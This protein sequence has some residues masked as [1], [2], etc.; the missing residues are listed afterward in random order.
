MRRIAIFTDIH[1][2]YEPLE[3]ILKD[4]KSKNIDE[5]YS[6]G[7][8]VGLGPNP[9]ECLELLKKYNVKNVMGN[10]E[11]YV[12][13]G[14]NAFSYF[15]HKNKFRYQKWTD[16][17]LDKNDIDYIKTFK[18]SFILELG[19]KKI[20]LCHFVND[21]RVDYNKYS[22]WSYQDSLKKNDGSAIKQFYY[23]NS[24]EQKELIKEK[25]NNNDNYSIAY[26][27]SYNDPI[28]EGHTIDYFDQIFQ[29][30]V[31]FPSEVSD[32]NVIIT[33]LRGVSIAF[34]DRSSDEAYYV[35]LNEEDG[36]YSIEDCYVKFDRKK[37]IDTIVKSDLTSKGDILNY[38]NG[39]KLYN[40][41]MFGNESGAN[42]NIKYKIGEVNIAEKWNPNGVDASEMG[43]FNFST[44]DKIFRW[45]IRGNTIYD[46][47]IP[48]D[49]S[50]ICVDEDKG[51]YRSNKIILYNPHIVDD[52][53]AMYI[54]K[55]SKLPEKVYYKALAGAAIRGYRNT[56]LKLINDKINKDNVDVVLKEID[57]FVKPENSD[58]CASN[59]VEV[60]NEVISILKKIKNVK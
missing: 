19:G 48:E 55:V 40:R 41:V 46:C 2:L 10:S 47:F 6:L 57:D 39:P 24:D 26:K 60:Y 43:G 13:L 12:L 36:G 25:M 37:M 59:G 15:E 32:S 45:L 29:G 51:V 17:K 8:V 50:I 11:E 54:Y 38:V 33:T 7:D 21:V 42:N 28:L 3:A 53:E 56:C 14:G 20:G 16:S 9:K 49:A 44:I 23:A 52:E 5:I 35:I 4:I 30:H 22:T 1:G 18:H 34:E 58:G 31:H 27:S